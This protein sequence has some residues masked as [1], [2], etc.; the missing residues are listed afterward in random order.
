MSRTEISHHLDLEPAA[1]A[2]AK[3]LHD[4]SRSKRAKTAAGL[5]LAQGRP[6][7]TAEKERDRQTVSKQPREVGSRP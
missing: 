6:A 1:R 5:A 3:I 7:A 4:P 2:A